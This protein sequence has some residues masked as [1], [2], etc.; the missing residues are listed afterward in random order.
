MNPE[1]CLTMPTEPGWAPHQRARRPSASERRAL[2]RFHKLA[3]VADLGCAAWATDAQSVSSDRDAQR[4]A[5][6]AAVRELRYP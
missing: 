4:V 1:V 3:I 5:A 2:D 6:W